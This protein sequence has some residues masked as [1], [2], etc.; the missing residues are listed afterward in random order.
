MSNIILREKKKS[1]VKD[2]AKTIQKSSTKTNE[3][4]NIAS[5]MVS[6]EAS[7]RFILAFP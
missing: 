5:Y 2:K 3:R 1:F 7:K 6:C 4:M